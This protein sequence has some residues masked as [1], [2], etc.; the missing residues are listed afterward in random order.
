MENFYFSPFINIG[1]RV[2]FDDITIYKR[3]EGGTSLDEYNLITDE[4]EYTKE[5]WPIP[6]FRAGFIVGY[7]F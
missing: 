3:Y 4:P 1:A 7:R 2:R 6:I 5:V